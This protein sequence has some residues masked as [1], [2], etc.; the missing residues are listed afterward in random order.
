M[1]REEAFEKLEAMGAALVHVSYHGGGDQGF[2]DD[3]TLLDGEGKEG[4]APVSMGEFL[5]AELE[6]A[7]EQ[8]IYD[9]LGSGFGDGDG[10]QGDITWN[11][12]EREILMTHR[13]PEW[14]EEQKKL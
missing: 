9:E 4:E 14:Q 3:V 2:V 7:L 12:A 5:D 1:T 8:P 11:V 6:E 10:C 13:Y